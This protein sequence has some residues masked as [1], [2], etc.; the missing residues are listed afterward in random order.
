MQLFQPPAN[1]KT[2]PVKPLA[3]YNIKAAN[4]QLV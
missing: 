2:L 4:F 3:N 1:G